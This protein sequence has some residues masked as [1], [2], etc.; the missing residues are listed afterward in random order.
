MVRDAQFR[1]IPAIVSI[2]RRALDRSVYADSGT[3]DEQ[4]SKQ[5]LMHSIQRHGHTNLGGALVLVS[6]GDEGRVC[7]FVIGF[8]DN[9]YPGMVERM[10]TDLLFICEEGTPAHDPGIII[11][12]L[13]EWGR[14]AP[15]VIEIHL[16]VSGAIGDPERTGR[17]YERAGLER[18][19]AMYRM[20][21]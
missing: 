3:F 10:A 15:K 16:G 12:R 1:D 8:I 17:L 21:V 18:C 13:V 2:M 7:G 14:S 19:G 9:V 11:R 20:E 5:L 6:E 4:G